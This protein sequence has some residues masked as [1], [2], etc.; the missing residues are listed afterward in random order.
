M[1]CDIVRPE[2]AALT[3][4][5]GLAQ[6]IWSLRSSARLDGPALGDIKAA[7]LAGDAS[8]LATWLKETHS[9]LVGNG[10]T[11]TLVLP[12]D[13]AEEL[14][15]ADAG[16]EAATFLAILG[17]L[18]QAD[19]LSELPL[20][21]VATIRADRYE[22]LQTAAELAD[23]HSR[24]FSDLKP[25]PVTEFKE[26]ITGPAARATTAG[27]RVSVDPELV[28]QLLNDVAGGGD[29]LPLLALTLSR[30][31]LDYGS[32]GR[33]TLDHYQSMGGMDQH[34]QCRDRHTAFRRRRHAVST[35]RNAAQRVH[36]LVGHRRPGHRPSLTPGR[37]VG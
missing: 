33:L 17:R 25:M 7:C 28:S 31:Y 9:E 21:A 14:F 6:S 20:I 24:E 29:S 30:L 13:Q 16:P 4:E 2:R 3:G 36:S 5:H 27:L 22:L 11:P 34:R 15:A 18:L 12:I 32:T 26:V 23:V 10:E 1:V 8:R 35:A 19:S 37:T